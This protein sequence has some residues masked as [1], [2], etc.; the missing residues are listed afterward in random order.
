[1]RRLLAAL[2]LL[3]ACGVASA[4]NTC[5]VTEFRSQ[6]PP[7]YQAA[8]QIPLAEQTIT[9]SGSST[10]SSAFQPQTTLVRV[11]CDVAVSFE[12]GPGTPVASATT[13]FLPSGIVEYFVVPA[14]AAYKVAVITNS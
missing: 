10:A 12:F 9:A 7:S 4:A 8:V 14:G 3:A 2:I 6:S 5:F 1:M 13:A 11:V